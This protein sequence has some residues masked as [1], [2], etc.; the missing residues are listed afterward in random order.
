MLICPVCR[1]QNMETAKFCGNCGN[2]FPRPSPP[3]SAFVNCAQGHTYAAI[4]TDCPYCPQPANAANADFDTRIGEPITAIEPP[5]SPSS[6]QYDFATRIDPGPTMFETRVDQ[7][8]VTMSAAA[9]RSAP[10]INSPTSAPTEVISFKGT[11]LMETTIADEP[12]VDPHAELP[13]TPTQPPPPPTEPELAPRP[14]P[15]PPPSEVPTDP[16]PVSASESLDLDRRT[17]VVEGAMAAQA[18]GKIIGWLISYNR[19]PDGED[20]RVYS[21]YNRLGANPICDIVIEDETVSGSH[22]ILVYRDGR[23]LLK[24]DLSRNGTFVN[25]REISEAHPLQNYDQIRVGNTYLTFVAA[26]RD[27]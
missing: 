16:R 9:P 20:F 18:K 4:Y 14:A 8:A 23:C 2:A 24:D 15:P 11:S 7:E 6:P 12:V 1:S 21:G 17:T 26:Q 22:A 3:S 25:G 27:A 13:V 5:S 19:N 10:A